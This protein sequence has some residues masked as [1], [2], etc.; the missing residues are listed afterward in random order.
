MKVK[1]EAQ[2]GVEARGLRVKGWGR[3]DVVAEKWQRESLLCIQ[4]GRKK[5]QIEEEETGLQ[6]VTIPFPL[7]YFVA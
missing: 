1:A 3:I 7:M 6:P 2:A 4:D 5:Y